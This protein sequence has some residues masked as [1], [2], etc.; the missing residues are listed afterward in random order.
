[1]PI[2][3]YQG[4]QSSFG[5]GNPTVTWSSNNVAGNLLVAY[6]VTRSFPLNGSVSDG[7]NTWI[8]LFPEQNLAGSVFT[9][10]QAWY[11]PNC[12]ASISPRTVTLTT[13]NS[14]NALMVAEFS[15]VT[16]LDQVSANGSVTG[17]P[18]VS[19]QITPSSSNAL[20]IGL[21]GNVSD[22]IAHVPPGA[23]AANASYAAMEYLIISSG[24]AQSISTTG[25]GNGFGKLISFIPTTVAFVAMASRPQYGS[26]P[27]MFS[28]NVV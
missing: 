3:F 16:Q 20:L 18:Y 26:G 2:S 6:G 19:P 12:L 14:N 7:A 28:G 8:S 10:F 13:S 23:D 15:G 27:Q 21:F 4:G 11:V 22:S 17:S 5:G 24:G 25:S 9:V 1:M